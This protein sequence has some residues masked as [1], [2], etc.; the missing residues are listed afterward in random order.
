MGSIKT[1]ISLDE[2]LLKRIDELSKERQISRSRLFTLAMKDYLKKQ[3]NQALLAQLNQAYAGEPE[4]KEG[5]LM[6]SMKAKY[7]RMIDQES[8]E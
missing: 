7:G 4:E 1:A 5:M 3:E 8:W 6:Q 2:D